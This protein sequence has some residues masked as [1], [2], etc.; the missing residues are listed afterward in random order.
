[1][2][3]AIKCIAVSGAQGAPVDLL[4]ESAVSDTRV[5]GPHGGVCPAVH[6]ERDVFVDIV[7]QRGMIGRHSGFAKRQILHERQ[8]LSFAIGSRSEEHTSELQSRENLVCRL[9]LEK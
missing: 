6:H 3:V 8:A 9:L 4:A 5:M 2:T 1:M 7:S